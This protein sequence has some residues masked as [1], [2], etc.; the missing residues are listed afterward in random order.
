MSD[1]E[2]RDDELEF[3]LVVSAR[4]LAP[5]PPL[6]KERVIVTDWPTTSGKAAAFLV[7]ELTAGDYADMVEAG[8]VYRDGAFQRFNLPYEDFRLLAYVVRDQHGNR[9][10]SSVDAAKGQLRDLGKASLNLLLNAASRVNAV[11]VA[12][13]EG[14]SEETPND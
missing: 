2:D 11:K 9:L 3:E 5:P 10:W 6:R 8:R 1:A 7:W 13:A 12:A 14:N 4:Q